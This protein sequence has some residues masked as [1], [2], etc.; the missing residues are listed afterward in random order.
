MRCACIDIGS[1]TT[2]LLVADAGDDG[3]RL[4]GTRRVFTMLGSS[5]KDG[6]IDAGKIE[7]V[8]GAVK[9]FVEYAR[10][11]GAER[12]SVVATHVLR[13][14]KDSSV[15]VQVIERHCGLP[16]RVLTTAEEAQYSFTGAV[17]GRTIPGRA[18]IVVDAG[19]GSTEVTW[20]SSGGE[21]SDLR[22]KSFAIGSSSL[23]RGFL[24]SDPPTAEELAA[25]RAFA[26]ETFAAL[27]VPAA[28]G[29]ALAVG[30]GATTAREIVGGLIDERSVARVLELTTSMDSEQ[31]ANRLE[32]EWQRARLLPAGLIV[33]AAASARLG[34][35]LE[36]GL[37]GLREGVIHE[38]FA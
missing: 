35:P 17:G 31:L 28:C 4:V 26:D 21:L 1:N 2:A 24:H 38:L 11:L 5:L 34:L 9:L 30:G 32:I 18:T 16:V 3:L 19:G 37:G 22:T 23:R 13:E 36:V 15:L 12:I 25:A 33:L 7:E 8:C 27:D 6:Q 20:S 14:V 29:I 10:R